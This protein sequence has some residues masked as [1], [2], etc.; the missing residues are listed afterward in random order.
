MSYRKNKGYALIEVLVAITIISIVLMTVMSGVS[1]GITAISGNKNQIVA[2]IIAKNV[3]NEYQLK[4]MRGTDVKDEQVKEY[5]GFTFS[6]VTERFEH[7]LLGPI[8]AKQVDITVDWKE[9]ERKK[10]YSLSYI[11]PSK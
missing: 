4:R 7:E 2:M 6:R 3:L 11:F 8:D 5:P 9:G 10:T 1:A